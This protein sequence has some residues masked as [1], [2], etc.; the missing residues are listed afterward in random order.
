[1]K[2]EVAALRAEAN[3]RA[4]LEA[5]ATLRPQVDGF[6][7]AVMVMDPDVTVRGNRLALLER[8][9]GDFGGIAEFSDIVVA[10]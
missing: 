5:I 10:G 4:A 1:L 2:P 7:D 9:L 3:Y 6:F 8:V